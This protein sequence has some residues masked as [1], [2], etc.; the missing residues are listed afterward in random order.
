M[1]R[2]STTGWDEGPVPVECQAGAFRI[3]DAQI[4]ADTGSSGP[5]SSGTANLTIQGNVLQGG[6]SANQNVQ[7]PQAGVQISR[8][9][10][11][12][13]TSPIPRDRFIFNTSW[14][15]GARGPGQTQN[16]TR[17]VPGMEWML[18][19][20]SSVEVRLPF[21]STFDSNQPTD[22]NGQLLGASNTEFGNA[23]VSYKELLYQNQ[24]FALSAGLAL[25]LPTADDF[26][27]QN[28]LF[29][30]TRSAESVNLMPFLGTLYTKDR[31]FLQTFTQLSFDTNGE[32]VKAENVRDGGSAIIG[33]L[34][35]APLIFGDISTGYW[36]YQNNHYCRPTQLTGLAG[37]LELHMTQ[38]L[39][40][41]DYI[42]TRALDY[43]FQFGQRNGS[44]GVANLTAGTTMEFGKQSV[45]TFAWVSPLT[46]T[47][48][49]F[50]GELQ[51]LFSYYFDKLGSGF[52][53][54][55]TA[56]R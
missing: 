18:D 55:R 15:D 14:F 53:S 12:E 42:D 2:H 43:N 36:F 11:G 6:F 13:Q 17:F 52:R 37:M 49:Q 51:V 19:D 56:M 20:S 25:Q 28:S 24:N 4:V 27:I 39:T 7:L 44:I 10:I 8:Y 9:K 29:R 35:E 40:D 54:P 5:P 46:K 47:D 32:T 31:F 30:I 21:A 33:R 1:L 22:A 41:V 16:V 50:N 38:T 23:V 26:V 45:L 34:Q 3:Q 48:K